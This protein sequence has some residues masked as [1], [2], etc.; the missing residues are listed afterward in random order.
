MSLSS[1]IHASS[2]L[3]RFH[4]ITAKLLAMIF[5]AMVPVTAGHAAH[6]NPAVCDRPCLEGLLD[7][8]LS[9][10]AAREPTNVPIAAQF[11]ATE[12]GVPTPLGEGHWETATGFGSYRIRAIDPVS[13]GAV[14]IGV[15]EEGEQSTMYSVRLRIRNRQIEDVETILARVGFPGE[16]GRAAASLGIARAGF[17]TPLTRREST[18][19]R[20]MIAAAESYYTGIHEGNAR[21]V[22]FAEEC[23]RIENGIALVNNPNF[24]F[25]LISPAGVELPSFAA[26]GCREQ[27]DTGLWS[28]DQVSG[29]RFPV[30]DEVHGIVAVYSAYHPFARAPCAQVREI[31]AVCPRTPIENVSLELLELFRI[32]RGQIHEMESVWTVRLGAPSN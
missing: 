18:S 14:F 20:R 13:G 28:A 11:N 30:V 12:N 29:L 4:P 32:R 6:D 22:A 26:M 16:P 2:R 25:D 9:A 5:A 7:T 3:L 21:H 24:Q 15:L 27:F 31:G 10:L 8:Y 1:I 17:S 19:R 23:H